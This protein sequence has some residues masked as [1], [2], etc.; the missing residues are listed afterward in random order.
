MAFTGRGFDPPQLHQFQQQVTGA[1]KSAEAAPGQRRVSFAETRIENTETASSCVGSRNAIERS[2][3]SRT[4]CDPG[5]LRSRR[6]QVRD[7]HGNRVR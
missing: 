6:L 5:Q 7:T 4:S 3:T 1:A 2:E